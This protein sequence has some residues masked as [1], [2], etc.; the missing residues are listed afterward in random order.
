MTTIT[1][2]Q[3]AARLRLAV[4]RLARRL[5]QQAPDG[6]SPSQLSVLSTLESRAELSLSELAEAER[7]RPPTITR[8]V[9]LLEEAGLI[10]RTADPQDRRSFR[11]E[12]T[13]SGHRLIER[14]RKQ[15]NA[16]LARQISKLS[17]EDVRVLDRAAGVIERMVD[18]S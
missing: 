9:A 12:L 4:M 18:E 11:V 14:N 15:K 5:R 6:I 8:V 10:R 3:L 17:E 1:E 2:A 13:A 7:V 16:Y